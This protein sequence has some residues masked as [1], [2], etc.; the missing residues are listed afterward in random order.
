VLSLLKNLKIRQQNL[1]Q[2][3]QLMHF[4]KNLLAKSSSIF[5]LGFACTI[6]QD[7]IGSQLA[8]R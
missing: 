5:D 2:V 1:L 4:L 6:N 7:L 8:A 3:M